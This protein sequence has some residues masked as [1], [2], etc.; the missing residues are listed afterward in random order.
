MTREVRS[1]P[2]NSVSGMGRLG[3]PVGVV[4]PGHGFDGD[5]VVTLPGQ[6]Y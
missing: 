5:Q 6:P 2:T 3:G 1:L 4:E